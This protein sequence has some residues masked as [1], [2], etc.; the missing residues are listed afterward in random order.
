MSVVKLAGLTAGLDVQL[1]LLQGELASLQLELNAA[2]DISAKLQLGVTPPSLTLT[3]ALAASLDLGGIALSF[4]LA[5]QTQLEIIA[6]LNLRIA[7]LLARIAAI[8]LQLQALAGVALYLY[9]GPA[10]QLS[11]EVGAYVQAD[12]GTARTVYAPVLVVADPAVFVT[13]RGCMGF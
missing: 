13:V 12:F 7:D 4:D 6:R 3:A 2:L 1:S 8:K 11:S 10:N 5:I 9:T